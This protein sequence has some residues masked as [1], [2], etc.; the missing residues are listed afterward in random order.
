MTSMPTSM[1][2][3]QTRSQNPAY[4]GG[5]GVAAS[6]FGLERSAMV[7]VFSGDSASTSPQNRQNLPSGNAGLPQLLQTC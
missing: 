2:P 6:G 3:A 7:E 5:S 4:S 1:V